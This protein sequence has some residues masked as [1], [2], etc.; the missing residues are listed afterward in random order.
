MFAIP[1]TAIAVALANSYILILRPELAAVAGAGTVLAILAVDALTGV[2]SGIYNSVLFGMES[3]DQEKLTFKSMVKS[4][5]FIA[6]SLPYVHSAVTIPTTYFLLT[7]F[8]YQQPL[9]AALSVC[10]I[11]ST[12]RFVMFLVLVGVVRGVMKIH[13]PWRSVAKYALASVV[14]GVVLYLLPTATSVL[15]TLVWTAIGGLLYLALL[16]LIDKETRQL[17]KDIL[18]ELRGHKKLK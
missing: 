5:I 16:M 3:V 6:F 4:K 11:N 10:I 18:S 17:P 7:T 2:I 9:L 8:A 12:M 1:M 15:V 13:F 14:T